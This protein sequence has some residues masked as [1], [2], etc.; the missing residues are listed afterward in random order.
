MLLAFAVALTMQTQSLA[1]TSNSTIV[2]QPFQPAR[3]KLAWSDEFN[4]GTAP[5]PRFW[6]FEEGYLRNGEAQYYTKD[7]PENARIE[8]GKLI[9]EARKDNWNGKP[10]TS[11][12]IITKG[13]RPFLYGRIEVRAK[14]PTGRGAWPAIWTLGENIDQIGWP[15]SGELDIMENVGY[16]PDRIHANI[17]TGAYNHSIKTGKGNSLVRG[18]PY[19]GFHIY[20]VEWSKDKVAFFMDD[21]RYFE[22]FNDGKGDNETWPFDKPQY[23]ILN[24]AVGG[25]WGGQQGIDETKFPHRMEVDYVRYYTPK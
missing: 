22:F 14:L 4:R 2:R 13:K 9:I 6:S 5:D 18:K 17:H 23:L 12:S 7:R 25:A 1:G 15:K 24:V 8:G 20:A 10:I 11:A 19:E 3:W 16:D 21:E